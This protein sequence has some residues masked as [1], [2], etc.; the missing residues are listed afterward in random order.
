MRAVVPV[1]P[2]NWV[3]LSFCGLVRVLLLIMLCILCAVFVFY[4][5]LLCFVVCCVVG[6]RAVSGESAG[7]QT[8]MS[9]PIQ[10]LG[11]NMCIQMTTLSNTK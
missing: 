5:L 11:V 2:Q 1:M 10:F 7:C 8:C 9:I 4:L 6:V 3:T